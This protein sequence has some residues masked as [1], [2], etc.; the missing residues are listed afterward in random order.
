MSLQWFNHH[1][2]WRRE[3]LNQDQENSL[4]A[5]ISLLF[6]FIYINLSSDHFGVLLCLFSEEVFTP[7]PF[8]NQMERPIILLL[9]HSLVSLITI[10]LSHRNT[11]SGPPEKGVI[12][13]F[14]VFPLFSYSLWIIGHLTIST[15]LPHKP[16]QRFFLQFSSQVQLQRI[17]SSDLR[18]SLITYWNTWL[19]D[20]KWK[21]GY[22]CCLL[23]HFPKFTL[24]N[25]LFTCREMI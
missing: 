22:F 3:L 6:L 12:P 2:K 16:G 9:L 24:H 10:S 15:V 21:H 4:F 17:P 25:V 23:S 1:Y 8:S 18:L 5:E 7:L 14:A 20:C 19:I 11:F 13:R